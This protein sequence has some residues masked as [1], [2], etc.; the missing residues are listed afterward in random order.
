MILRKT[1]VHSKF[2]PIVKT[3]ETCVASRTGWCIVR[4][5][6]ECI[7]QLSFKKPHSSVPAYLKFV[8]HFDDC[9][10]YAEYSRPLPVT[11][12]SAVLKFTPLF[13]L[14]FLHRI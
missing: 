10:M 4:A 3:W 9:G 2:I 13:S 6:P 12:I 1:Y 5:S 8:E 11:V 14:L 7:M